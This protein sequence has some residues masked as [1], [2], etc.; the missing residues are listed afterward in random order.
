G[1]ADTGMENTNKKMSVSKVADSF[2]IHPPDYIKLVAGQ[3]NTI[4]SYTNDKY[5][6]FSQ[7]SFSVAYNWPKFGP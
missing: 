7:K 1:F 3:L 5:N 6:L 4:L 2:F